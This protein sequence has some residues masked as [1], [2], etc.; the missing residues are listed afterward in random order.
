M[1]MRRNHLL[2]QAVL[3]HPGSGFDAYITV[4]VAH[5][6]DPELHSCLTGYRSLLTDSG[7]DLVHLLTLDRIVDAWRAVTSPLDAAIRSWLER[8]EQGY[9]PLDDSEAAWQSY[10]ATVGRRV[11]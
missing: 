3:D 9:V 4:V 6:A 8:F 7:R 10:R 1:Q 5:S 2:A 11:T